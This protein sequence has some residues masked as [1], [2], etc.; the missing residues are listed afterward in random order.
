VKTYQGKTATARK[1]LL[2]IGVLA[3]LVLIVLLSRASWN[4]YVKQ[5]A[6]LITRE[7][8]EKELKYLQ[9]QQDFLEDEVVRLSRPEGQEAELR[10]KF[11]VALPGEEIVVIIG[12]KSTTSEIVPVSEEKSVWERVREFFGS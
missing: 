9:E 6:T 5:R 7:E 11:N 4:I 3:L 12:E 8:A 2:I 1:A 10:A